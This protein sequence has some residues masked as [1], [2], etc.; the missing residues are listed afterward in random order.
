MQQHF[1]IYQTHLKRPMTFLFGTSSV[2]FQGRV[3]QHLPENNHL[4]QPEMSGEKNPPERQARAEFVSSG[5]EI[6][7]CLATL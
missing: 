4:T 3:P 7:A 2:Y 1:I 5:K 6:A